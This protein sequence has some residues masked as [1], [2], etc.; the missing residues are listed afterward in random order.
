LVKA[1]LIDVPNDFK[2]D[3]KLKLA[4]MNKGK[5]KETTQREFVM[6]AITEKFNREGL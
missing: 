1:I 2:T 5:T 4:R 3:F 6:Q